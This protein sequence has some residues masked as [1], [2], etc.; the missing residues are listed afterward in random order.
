MWKKRQNSWVIRTEKEIEQLRRNAIVHKKVFEEI[1]KVLKPWISAYDIDKLAWDICKKY[2]VLAWFKWVYGFPANICIS[3]NDV[4]VHWVPTKK[5]IFKKWDVVKF[6]FWVKDKNIWINTDAAITLI[7]WEW[8]HDPLVEKF[9][10]VNQEALMKWVAKCIVWNR[11]WDIGYA[12]QKHV[13]EN[14]FHIVRDLTGHGIGYKLHEKPYIYNYWKPGTWELLK[15]NMSLAIEP[16]VWM[17]TWEI[18]EVE[19]KFEIYMADWWLWSQF[20]HTIIVKEAYPEI[21]V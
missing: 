15:K 12:I 7:V 17:T 3:I 18:K 10:R 5:M 11:T 1:K 14:W 16:I 21:I 9:L 20:E 8:P 19:W 13:E 6:D 4:V 2:N